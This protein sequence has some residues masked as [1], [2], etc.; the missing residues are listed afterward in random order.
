MKIIIDYLDIWEH[1][2]KTAF[3]GALVGVT[4]RYWVFNIYSGNNLVY[5]IEDSKFN[6]GLKQA[7]KIIKKYK[8][9]IGQVETAHQFGNAVD[10]NVVW[11]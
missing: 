1:D 9:E 5:T 8:N 4:P 6:R 10:G 7:T 3:I 11:E 2:S